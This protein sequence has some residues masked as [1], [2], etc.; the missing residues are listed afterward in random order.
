MTPKVTFVLGGAASGKSVWAEKYALSLARNPIYLATAQPLDSEMKQKIEIH[1][2]RREKNWQTIEEPFGISNILEK[3]PSQKTILIDCIT[4]WLSNIL[5]FGKPTDNEMDILLKSINK[6][7]G[8]LI[9]VSNEVGQGIIPKNKLARD[10]TMAQGLLN[11]RIA[12]K[13][14]RVILV[15]A[16]LPLAIKGVLPGSNYG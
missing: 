12:N 11:Q 10:F 14:D 3:T 5:S 8:N 7:R 9:L 6:F 13:A 1:K 16:G 2:K 4:I 15:S